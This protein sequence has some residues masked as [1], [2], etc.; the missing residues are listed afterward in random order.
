[1][2]TTMRVAPVRGTMLHQF[3]ELRVRLRQPF[4]ALEG[5]V[6]IEKHSRR[7]GCCCAAILFLSIIRAH[8]YHPI[9]ILATRRLRRP[10][11]RGRAA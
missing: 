3:A 9:K 11:S 1:M 7:L 6:Q 5:A 2:V 8:R 10:T 4:E